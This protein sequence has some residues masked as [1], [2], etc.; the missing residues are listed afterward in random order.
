M[1]FGKDDWVLLIKSYFLIFWVDWSAINQFDKVNWAMCVHAWHTNLVIH[2]LVPSAKGSPFR[3]IICLQL[4]PGNIHKIISVSWISFTNDLSFYFK[5]FNRWNSR[6]VF[7]KLFWPTAAFEYFFQT[8]FILKI[9]VTTLLCTWP[10]VRNKGLINHARV[11]KLIAISNFDVCYKR[12][13]P[14]NFKLL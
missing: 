8:C 4:W 13:I 14:I 11:A 1:F 10:L 5:T 3:A 6:L 12:F 2:S 9:T 7:T